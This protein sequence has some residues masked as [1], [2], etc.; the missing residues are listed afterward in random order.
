MAMNTNNMNHQEKLKHELQNEEDASKFESLISSLLGRLLDVPVTVASKGFQ[1][2]ADAGP[3]GQQG[4]RFRL[5]CKKYRD[6]TRFN[7][8]ELLG[9]ID[10]ALNR[11]EAL[12]AWVLV[13]TGS[14][15]EQV[16]QSLHQ[17]GE[18]EGVPILVLDW[19]EGD[20]LPQLAALCAYAPD[21]VK[22]KFSEEAGDAALALK[23]VSGNTIEKLKRELQSWC[24]GFEKLREV[25]HEELKK[26]WN[27]PQEASAEFGQNV[28]GGAQ[29]K[30]IKRNPVDNALTS[31]WQDSK[32]TLVAVVGY[33]GVGKTWATLHWLVDHIATQPVILTI[34]SSSMSIPTRNVSKTSVKKF[35]ADRLH[36]ITQVRDSQHWLRRLHH[37][38]K[39]PVDEGTVLTLF[40][41]GL[42][43][44]SS[45]NWL[46]LLSV[47]QGETF[48]GRVRIII[49]T[50][51][52]YFDEKLSRFRRFGPQTSIEVDSFDTTP[53]GEF[54]QML[55]FEGLSQADLR[56]DVIELARN[57]RLFRLVIRLREKL[58][59]PGEI[60]THRLL[61]EYGRDSF[62]ERAGKSFSENEWKEWLIEIAQ[63]HRNGIR[64]FSSR[65][66]GET[67]E[68]PDL[69]ENA[70]YQRLS[71]II[72]GRFTAYE[73]G[74]YKIIPSVLYHCLGLVLLDEL[75]Q[76]GSPTLEEL[77]SKL[78]WLEPIS[79]FDNLAEILRAAVSILIEQNH[80][81]N[82]L[83]S[84]IL[85]T[86]WMQTQNVPESHTEELVNLAPHLPEALLDAVENSNS[87]V[88]SS[89]R[90]WAVR[91]L[92]VIPRTDTEIFSLIV[93]RVYRWLCVVSLDLNASEES[94]K[95][96]SEHFREQVETYVP[97]SI[98]ILGVKLE[99]VNQN[100]SFLK[101]AVPSIIEGFPLSGAQPVFKAAA[102]ELAMHN[103]SEAW[104]GL[105]WLCL[106]N[107]V[108]PDDTAE[109]LRKLSESVLHEGPEPH[110]HQDI[111]ARV[112]ALLLW[113]TGQEKDDLAAAEINPDSFYPFT[114]DKDYLP[115]PCKSMFPLERRH[116]GIVLNNKETSLF[117]R[118]RR[119]KDLWLDPSFQ[120]PATFV[121]EVRT[122]IAS[123]DVEKLSRHRSRTEEDLLFE[124]L[125]PA[126]A[127]CSPD[128]LED[129][130][131]RKL[132]SM[133][134]CP[135]ESRYW[136][137][138][139]FMEH[140]MLAGFSE[141]DAA[142]KLRFGTNKNND[143]K[144]SHVASML[145]LVEILNM[146]AQE[147]FDELIKAVPKYIYTDL[148]KILLTPTLED[149]DKLI[150]RYS[151]GTVKQ[152]GDLITLL[153]ACRVGLELSEK[154]WLWIESFAMQEGNIR[155]FAFKI[156]T[157]SDP[158]RFG[159]ALEDNGWSWRPGEDLWVNHYGTLALAEATYTLPFKEL[160]PRLAP[161]LLLK[162]A[163]LRGSN[164][165]E[166]RL[167]AEAF[168]QILLAN[169]IEEPDPGSILSVDRV[170][171]DSWL[172]SFSLTLKPASTKSENL[173]RM[174][175]S[176][177]QTSKFN[178][179]LKTAKSRISEVRS[180]GASLYLT[181]IEHGDF[182]PFL[183]H[184]SDIVQ[185]W[186]GDLSNPT[187]EFRHC[188]LLA[189]GIFLALCEALLIHNPACGVRLWRIL[190]KTLK[191]RYLGV[192]GVEDLLHMVFR[193]PDS[194]EVIALR[195]KLIELE[196]CHTDLDLFNVVIAALYNDRA[197]WV[198]A[199]IREDEASSLAWRQRRAITLA[200]FTANNQLP[201][202]GAWPEGKIKTV[203]DRLRQKSAR[204]R[205][206]EACAHHW[207]QTFLDT[208]RP[209][210]AYAAW[211]LFLHSADRRVESCIFQDK[212]TA[213]NSND[214]TDI[215]IIHLELNRSDIRRAFNKNEKE[216]EKNF[217][218]SR[219][220]SN[221][222]P[223]FGRADYGETF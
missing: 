10:Q 177:F 222:G 181:D 196:N 133:K 164:P 74:N 43:Q 57:P 40:F 70:V 88:H 90:N 63:R 59:E 33:E 213:K 152:H 104:N 19:P 134:T 120:P 36:E 180:S 205:W 35:L 150:S 185:K 71:D 198:D 178:Q 188:I 11:D 147:Q 220:D 1:Y 110:I 112:A 45:F 151:N 189:E 24:L 8:R 141:A 77:E 159:G 93:K 136:G 166:V 168:G 163:C 83:V 98:N 97:G 135:V 27:S 79:G 128:L 107:E 28:A 111:P 62:G 21:I 210:H 64:K 81:E 54:D 6:S 15:S 2:G 121:N 208:P 129:F 96:C 174:L 153:S 61:W 171:E 145:L 102:I 85:V 157:R 48:S 194:P 140:F 67:V 186:L 16:R 212:S 193:V 108:D 123:I 139:S 46:D 69:D 217:L 148:D 5:E 4:R 142:H 218:G 51:N 143:D 17:K 116:A 216:L 176:E 3:A 221:V 130:I 105:K 118:L 200:G 72:D 144:E 39:R 138:L 155:N 56:P 49:S 119:T 53:G 9:E 52:H 50:R 170:N 156:L 207:W 109:A 82:P 206:I 103:N 173:R 175:D 184:A 187:A 192:S 29:D 22:S 219:I 80:Y 89:A 223:W 127:Q 162:V 68:R 44:E 211:V 26:I 95:W 214:L 55:E 94:K 99:L 100:P 202:A 41:D 199:L 60:T 37:L 58:L 169:N 154:S 92:R 132:R 34:P 117:F 86:A 20:E 125:A 47:L 137:A 124:D 23:P 84:G 25:S 38:L 146:D 190:R 161:W 31:W 115:D 203:H 197:D 149:I 204:Q 13:T 42:N 14:V 160:I 101:A 201:V 215:K 106:L 182:K 32:E 179:A 122:A 30:K 75:N 18:E 191:T 165:S 65:S 66:L 87:R 7:E 91:A 172:N 158:K 113:L 12:E 73:S 183:S 78:K 195:R 76:A 209:K 126:L 114:Y 167:A 131:K